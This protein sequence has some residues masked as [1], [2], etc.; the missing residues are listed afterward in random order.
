METRNVIYT[1]QRVSG[2]QF[3]GEVVETGSYRTVLTTA[4]TYP[5][6]AVAKVAARR[7]WA[8]RAGGQAAIDLRSTYLPDHKPQDEGLEF[9]LTEGERALARAAQRVIEEQREERNAREVRA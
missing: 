7:M 3:R 1:A 4:H 8:E 2:G 6:E 9:V 5:T